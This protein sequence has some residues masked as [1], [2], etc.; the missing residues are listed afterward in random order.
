MPN[1]TIII[2]RNSGFTLIELMIVIAIIG[3]LAAIAI[4]Q[5]FAYIETA[6][7]QTVAGNLKMA[8]DAVT[9]AFAASNNGDKT[10]IYSTLNGQSAHDVAD[11][12]YGTGTPAFVTGGTAS[13]CGQ[14][15]ISASTIS[16]SAPQQVSVM[17][18]TTG[19]SG[20]LGTVIARACSAAGFPSAATGSGVLITQNGK[21]TP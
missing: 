11:P 5:Y 15:A 3:I 9:N 17:V 21:V 20:N 4:P 14:V 8:V 7:A 13:A 10:D 12:V 16:Q 6:K 19:C 1:S 2:Q 18:K